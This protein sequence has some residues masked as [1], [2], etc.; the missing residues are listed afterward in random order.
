ML[1]QE[2]GK[3]S[4]KI[5]GAIPVSTQKPVEVGKLD[6]S[7]E[8]VKS[9]KRSLVPVVVSVIVAVVLLAIIVVVS[10]VIFQFI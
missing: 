1:F 10:V 8:P 2:D 6:K 4:G 7:E 9:T 3:E 5:P